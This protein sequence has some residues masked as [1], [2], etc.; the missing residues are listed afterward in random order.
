M[1]TL[2]IKQPW[3]ELVVSG[4]KTIELRKWNT[5]FRG[6]F[7]VHASKSPDAD[8]MKKFGFSEKD[9][10]LGKIIGKV[11]LKKVRDYKELG[12]EEFEKDK[13]RHLA[14]RKWGDFGFVL[15]NPERIKSIKVNGKLGFWDFEYGNI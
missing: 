8:A 7:L 12:D 15:E 11:F 14:E 1:K 9:L 13:G 4:K 6:E 2:S 5:K 10:P 3:A